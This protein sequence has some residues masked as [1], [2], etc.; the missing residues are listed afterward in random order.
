MSLEVVAGRSSHAVKKDLTGGQW[1]YSYGR[2]NITH[3]MSYDKLLKEVLD[4][5]TTII[6]L[7]E[8]GLLSKGRV[9]ECGYEMKLLLDSGAKACQDGFIWIC[10]RRMGPNKQ[11]H[12]KCQSIR[13]GS[14]FAN[15]NL[16]MEEIL[17]LMYWWSRKLPQDMVHWEIPGLGR[18]TSVDWY[19]FG[20]EVCE[21]VMLQDRTPIGGPGIIVEIDESKF[22]KRKYHMGHKVDGQWVFGGVER[23]NHRNTFMVPV[24]KRDSNTLVPQIQQWIHRGSLL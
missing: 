4:K 24:E 18:H 23:D 13:K 3:G 22:G 6:W 11:I 20:R 16:N 14:W 1:P 19:N 2:G 10:R 15:A 17:R 21:S 8:H 12:Q 9:C 7:Q 5:R